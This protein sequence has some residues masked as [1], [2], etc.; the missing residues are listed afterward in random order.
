M[1]IVPSKLTFLKPKNLPNNAT[2]Q[3]HKKTSQTAKDGKF[4]LF[5]NV[6][7]K[8]KTHPII[9]VWQQKKKKVCVVVVIV[10]CCFALS[11][12]LKTS[13]IANRL[14]STSQ[15]TKNN[16]TEVRINLILLFLLYSFIS[17]LHLSYIY[18]FN[19]IFWRTILFWLFSS[20]FSFWP[21]FSWCFIWWVVHSTRGWHFFLSI[22]FLSCVLLRAPVLQFLN[23]P[24]A[25]FRNRLARRM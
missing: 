11:H 10:D 18:S 8:I 9:S 14:Y 20:S 5:L 23:F 2:M 4:L 1:L 21:S 17:N 7:I 15:N 3:Q 25:N 12:C 16:K 22:V 6:F 19:I 24:H 13:K